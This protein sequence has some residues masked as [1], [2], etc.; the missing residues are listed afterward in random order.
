MGDY[1]VFEGEL[2][3]EI[4]ERLFY[5]GDGRWREFGDV[6]AEEVDGQGGD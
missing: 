3:E 2:G 4:G 1:G 5:G 6:Q